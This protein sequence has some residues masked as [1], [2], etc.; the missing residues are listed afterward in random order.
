MDR[1]GDRFVLVRELGFGGMS[2]VFLGRDE[3]LDRPVRSPATQ[4]PRA[5]HGCRGIFVPFFGMLKTPIL[6]EQVAQI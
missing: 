2:R 3:V 1:L 6:M 5:V 4:V